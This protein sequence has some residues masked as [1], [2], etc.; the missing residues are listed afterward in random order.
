M[1][2]RCVYPKLLELFSSKTPNV[3]GVDIKI[4]K[5]LIFFLITITNLKGP[6]IQ[7][8][9]LVQSGECEL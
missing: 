8:V 5:L 3:M 7:R 9:Y 1:L 2:N 6:I 4:K